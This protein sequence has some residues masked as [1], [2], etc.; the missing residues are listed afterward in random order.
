MRL[1]P[2]LV[3]LAAC[4]GRSKLDPS[5]PYSVQHTPRTVTL[6]EGVTTEVVVSAPA[7]GR[8]AP[9]V[10]LVH[11]PGPADMDN[12]LSN[13]IDPPVPLFGALAADLSARG[14]TVVR[15]HQRHVRGPRQHDLPAFIADRSQATFAADL[16]VVL[17]EA[18]GDARVDPD[19]VFLLGYDE[20]AQ[21]AMAVAAGDP[22]VAGVATIGASATPFR[23]RFTTA[24]TEQTLPYLERFAYQ[25]KLDGGLLARALHTAA[26]SIVVEQASMLAVSYSRDNRFAEPSPLVDRDRDGILSLDDEVEPAI[27]TLVDFAFG[28]LGSYTYRSAENALPT[29]F[30]QLATFERPFLALYG[31]NDAHT[32]RSH[33]EA[34]QLRTAGRASQEVVVLEGLGH[35]LGP[36]AIPLDDVHRPMADAALD[37][38]VAWLVNNAR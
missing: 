35:A 21:V 29:V 3:L 22:T 18:R 30:D 17:A 38:L 19:R 33:A 23:E 2:V 25:G 13:M 36:A 12:T 27:P 28:P 1:L 10:I 32:P 4:G 8:R 11:G 15:Y 20:G 5:T 6:A 7:G 31:G 26:A 24:F 37:A 9:T 14:F 16:E 34:M